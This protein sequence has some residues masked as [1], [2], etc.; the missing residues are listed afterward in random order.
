LKSAVSLNQQ[1]VF[2][3]NVAWEMQI[4][5]VFGYFGSPTISSFLPLAHAFPDALFAHF[6]PSP[7]GLKLVSLIEKLNP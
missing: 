7:H 2:K 1:T 4:K 5:H 6:C 3:K